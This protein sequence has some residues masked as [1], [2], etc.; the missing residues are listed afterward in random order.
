MREKMKR[1]IVLAVACAI[2]VAM[3]SA[4][5]PLTSKAES[6]GAVSGGYGLNNP[7][8][9]GS[10]VVTWDC[11]WFGN[12]WQEDTNGDGKADKC[13][14]KQPIKWRVLSVDGDDAFLLADK[15]LD[16]KK[17]NDGDKGVTWEACTMRSWLNGYGAEA[18]RDGK[19]YQDDSFLNHAFSEVQQS[20]IRVTN[21]VNDDNPYLGTEGGNDTLDKLYLLSIAEV[22]NP[23]YGFSSDYDKYDKGRRAKNTEYAKK[24]GAW[25]ETE[26]GYVGNGVWWLRSPGSPNN[27]ASDVNY[28]GYVFRGGGS[29]YNDDKVA[30]PALHLN[31]SSTSNWLYAGTI[32]SNGEL[33]E[34][35]P[36]FIATPSPKVT[37]DTTAATKET[38][39][40]GKVS[41]LKLSRRNRSVTVSWKRVSGAT[42][43]QI[44]YGT[45]KKWKNKK[46]KLTHKNKITIKKLKKKKTYYFRVRAYQMKEKSKKY[47]AWSTTKKVVIKI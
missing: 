20:A 13:D 40:V 33:N 7:M 26:Q 24:Q 36:A 30:R 21:V 9:D 10:G 28:Y 17:Y 44:C 45:S 11:V 8:T 35:R 23:A 12:Y 46:L 19:D 42:G 39:S 37:T 47:G 2:A 1:K 15:N 4:G 3:M 31:L 16:C 22:G 43:Y 5:N 34:G 27:Y 32:N 6:G 18:N 38:Q 41:S 14:A 25:T 29:V